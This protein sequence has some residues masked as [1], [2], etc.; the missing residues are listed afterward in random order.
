MLKKETRLRRNFAFILL[1]LLAVTGSQQSVRANDAPANGLQP[2]CLSEMRPR[3]KPVSNSP[4]ILLVMPNSKA[5]K[6]EVA[7]SL[8]EAHGTVI[9]SI[10]QGEM[11]CLLVQ[12]EKGQLENTEKKLRGDSEHFNVVQRNYVSEIQGADSLGEVYRPYT[13]DDPYFPSQWH[14]AAMNVQK[15]WLTSRG[16]AVTIAIADT[17]TQGNNSDLT[18]K[19]YPGLDVI[20]GTPTG[21]QDLSPSTSHGTLVATTAAAL[22]GNRI[23]TA[24]PARDSYVYPIRVA[25]SNGATDDSKLIKAI[26]EAGTHNIRILNMSFG[27]SNVQYSMANPKVHPALHAY[28]KW[29][30]DQ[31]N[32]MAF[33]SA[34]NYAQRDPNP[35]LSYMIMVSA[36]NPAYKLASFSNYGG[37]IW[38]AAPGQGIY[39]SNRLNRVVQVNGTSFSCPLVASVAAL[40]LAHKPSLK[41]TQVEEILVRSCHTGITL[42]PAWTEAYGFGMP[43][44][45]GAL[46]Y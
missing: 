33:V 28:L 10:G 2:P 44:A 19:T 14:L 34:G 12:T 5:E 39:A 13:P 37:P 3:Q 46:Q 43:D 24:A 1:S 18:G 4:D 35:R 17:G 6:D 41:N 32:G 42:A 22:T 11:T 30:H 38:F 9:G 20:N 8:R 31:R 15:A 29:Y 36:I 40:I 16:Q 45:A 23:F 27:M 7:E 25:D 21:N 26:Y